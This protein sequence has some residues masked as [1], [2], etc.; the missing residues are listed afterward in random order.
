MSTTSHHTDR[1]DD[2]RPTLDAPADPSADSSP[3]AAEGAPAS[4]T[5]G[6]TDRAAGSSARRGAGLFRAFWRWHFYASVL[7]IPVMLLLSV[8]GLVILYKDTVDPVQ[9]PGVLTVDVPAHGAPQP[10]SA[11]E[12][13]VKAA[14]PDAE[15]TAMQ[16]GGDDRAALFTLRLPGDR[17]RNVYVNPYTATVTGTIDPKGQWSDIVTQIHGHIVYGKISDLALGDDPLQKSGLTKDGHSDGKLTVGELGDR[18]IELAACWAIVMTITGYYLFLRGRRARLKQVGRKVRAAT[19]RNNHA[20]F[21]AVLGIGFLLLVV[22]GLPWTGVWG[23]AVQNYATSHGSSLWGDDAGAESTL[24]PKLKDIGSS[25][26]PPPWAEG[27]APMPESMPG[28]DHGSGSTSTAGTTSVGIDRAVAAAV[29]DGAVGPFYVTYPDGEKGVY[30]VLA[31]QWHDAATPHTPTSA[32]SARSTSTSTAGRSSDATPT[33]TTRSP[34]SSS[35]RGSPC[36][37]DGGWA[38]STWSRPRRSASG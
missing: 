4:E 34:P 3:T 12:A 10:P 11:L 18:M 31:D 26:T 25:S 9:H 20:R 24:A 38:A 17:T 15:I 29:A 36:T 16:Q 32:R 19:M 22:S 13:A 8:T 21:G 37:K 27:A 35:A 33:A 30:S 28:M 14:H 2:P 1:V 7:V 6:V 5:A 23:R